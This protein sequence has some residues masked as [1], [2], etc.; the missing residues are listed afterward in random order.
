MAA[1]ASKILE[2]LKALD[3]KNDE[4]WT[5]Q[6]APSIEK[7]TEALGEPVKRKEITDAAPTFNREEALKALEPAPDQDEVVKTEPDQD[8]GKEDE[9]VK[10]EPDPESSAEVPEDE[11][12]S[13]EDVVDAKAK[14]AEVDEEL[15]ALEKDL[16][17]I[18]AARTKLTEAR[19]KLLVEL[20]PVLQESFAQQHAGY[21]KAQKA[22][23]QGASLSK[24]ALT[25][26]KKAGLLEAGSAIDRALEAGRKRGFGTKRPTQ[27]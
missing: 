9:V 12:A 17:E 3:P 27:L 24:A 15:K 8:E 7:V 6:G 21:L 22:I 4:H 2:A 19:D 14:L 20:S 10:T 16:N 13:D 5:Q 11:N 18:N 26:L 23:R 25:E 1:E